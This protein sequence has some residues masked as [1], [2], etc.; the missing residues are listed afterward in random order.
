M[1]PDAG[2]GAPHDAQ[3]LLVGWLEMPQRG[4]GT[5]S[6][7]SKISGKNAVPKGA[8]SAQRAY[9]LSRAMEYSSCSSPGVAGSPLRRL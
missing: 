2:K 5:I 8:A 4:Q 9:P 6:T 1:A 7:T 3:N